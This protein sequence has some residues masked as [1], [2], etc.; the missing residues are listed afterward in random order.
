MRPPENTPNEHTFFSDA[1]YQE[2]IF[3]YLR[4]NAMLLY[5]YNLQFR[6]F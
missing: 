6:F 4:H 1:F 3:K 5:S 2:P